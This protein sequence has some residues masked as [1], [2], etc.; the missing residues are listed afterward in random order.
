MPGCLRFPCLCE[1]HDLETTVA[2]RHG[3]F[4]WSD[5]SFDLGYDVPQ[6]RCTPFLR[7][8]FGPNMHVVWEGGQ[9]RMVPGIIP[10]VPRFSTQSLLVVTILPPGNLI[11]ASPLYLHVLGEEK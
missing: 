1:P 7:L 6:V 2:L 11:T 3:G 10:T 9:P 8:L 4:P 5:G